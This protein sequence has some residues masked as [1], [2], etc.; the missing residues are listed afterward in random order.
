MKKAM[1]K[2]LKASV[3]VLFLLVPLIA[4]IPIPK[5]SCSSSPIVVSLETPVEGQNYYTQFPGGQYIHITGWAIAPD[6]IS[7]INV[8]M[9]D[10]DYV[11]LNTTL[12]ASSLSA[13]ADVP[14]SYQS[15]PGY[16]GNKGFSVDFN[17]NNAGVGSHTINV[18]V[19]DVN[20]VSQ[21]S[22]ADIYLNPAPDP[23]LGIVTPTS[24]QNFYCGGSTINGGP[25]P[26][27]A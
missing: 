19:T 26:H 14:A 12:N 17:T 23:V 7:S 6:G 25:S 13:S 5:A 3:C 10:T 11:Y 27:R 16:A 18:T 9:D 2:V 15:Y 4:C 20:G 1:K 22:S 24:G 21:T 8:K